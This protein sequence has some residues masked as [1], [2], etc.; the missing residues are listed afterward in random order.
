M[1]ILGNV[2][3]YFL[4]GSLFAE[5]MAPA[6]EALAFGRNEFVLGAGLCVV[7]GWALVWLYA[8]ARFRL[9]SGARTAI[10]VGIAVWFLSYVPVTWMLQNFGALR[11]TTLAAFALVGLGQT[12]AAALAGGWVHKVT[13]PVDARY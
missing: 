4:A 8:A 12:V 13:R 6:F 11:T 5:E 9:R 7:M 3:F 10:R 2:A 1:L